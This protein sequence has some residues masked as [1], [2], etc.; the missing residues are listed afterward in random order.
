MIEEFGA[1]IDGLPNGGR[2]HG[3]VQDLG[4]LH[5]D[6]ENREDVAVELRGRDVVRFAHRGN[7]N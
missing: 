6:V 2:Q 4:G 5:V 7:T 1:Q 3:A